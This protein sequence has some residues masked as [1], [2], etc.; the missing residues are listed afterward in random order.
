MMSAT[1]AT[2]RQALPYRWLEF[3]WQQSRYRIG[4][5]RNSW[6]I[7]QSILLPLFGPCGCS[8]GVVDPFTWTDCSNHQTDSVS[9][10]ETA[11]LTIEQSNDKAILCTRYSA[12]MSLQTRTLSA[13]ENTNEPT[14]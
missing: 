2:Q 5:N 6:K 13:L 8:P 3:E 4:L 12:W 7:Q 11:L 14:A 9:L 1:V 10:L